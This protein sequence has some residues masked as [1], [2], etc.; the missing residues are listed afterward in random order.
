MNTDNKLVDAFLSDDNDIPE[1]DNK[2]NNYER[3]QLACMIASGKSQEFLGKPYTLRD[4][5]SWS[6]KNVRRY[7]EIYTTYLAAKTSQSIRDVIIHGYTSLV[8]HFTNI[9]ISS[10]KLELQNDYIINRELDRISGVLNYMIG[11]TPLAVI[12]TCII[13]TKH[14]VTKTETSIKLYNEPQETDKN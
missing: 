8:N 5:E 6:D 13:T 7:H 1:D 12:N 14:V 11:G 4:L 2:K 3:Q 9:D 10:L